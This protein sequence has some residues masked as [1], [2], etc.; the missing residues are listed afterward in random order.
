MG[1]RINKD[2]R[3]GRFRLTC[4]EDRGFGGDTW[5]VTETED[6]DIPNDEVAAFKLTGDVGIHV[7]FFNS[8]EIG[9][10]NK[11]WAEATITQANQEISIENMRHSTGDYIHHKK[12][13]DDNIDGKVSSIRITKR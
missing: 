12:E 11:T 9:N 6:P 4:Y 8:S 3:G 10:R 5:V 7:E 2:V 1:I 13:D